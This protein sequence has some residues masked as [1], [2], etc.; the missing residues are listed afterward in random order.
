MKWLEE[1]DVSE[2]PQQYQKMAGLIGMEN[3]IKL[4]EHFGKLPFYFVSLDG[5]I[6]EKKRQ[7]IVRN[8]NGS[9]HHELARTTGYSLVW[10]Y[11]IL[12][13]QKALNKVKQKLLFQE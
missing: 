6:R 9:N 3:T 5:F 2:L 7:Y 13:E 4:I 10:V 8:F 11:E 1:I 12:R